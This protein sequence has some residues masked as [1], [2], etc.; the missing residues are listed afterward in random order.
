MG[1]E[2]LFVSLLCR[3]EKAGLENEDLGMCEC[4]LQRMGKGNA[5]SMT[6]LL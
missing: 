3:F 4:G 2:C 6:G 1:K 5:L